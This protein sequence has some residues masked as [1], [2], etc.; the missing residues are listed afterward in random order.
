MVIP[1]K[2]LKNEVNLVEDLP[3]ILTKLNDKKLTEDLTEYPDLKTH[4]GDKQLRA[5]G[6]PVRIRFDASSIRG[7]EEKLRAGLSAVVAVKVK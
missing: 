1:K 4:S 7:F 2:I 3:N 6:V 5:E